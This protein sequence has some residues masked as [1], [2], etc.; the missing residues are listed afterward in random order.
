MGAV[1]LGGPKQLENYLYLLH[2][3]CVLLVHLEWFGLGVQP[4]P[5]RWN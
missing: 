1:L 5:I 4:P 3:I 2:L